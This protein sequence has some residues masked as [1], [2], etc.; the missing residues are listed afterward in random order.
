MKAV[1]KPSFSELVSKKWPSTFI[2]G[3]IY[4]LN[5]EQKVLCVNSPGFSIFIRWHQDII[6]IFVSNSRTE[7][8][9]NL[10]VFGLSRVWHSSGIFECW[11]ISSAANIRNLFLSNRGFHPE[12]RWILEKTEPGNWVSHQEK[13][14]WDRGWE[15]W[16]DERFLPFA[17]TLGKQFPPVFIFRDMN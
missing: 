17:P 8:D 12:T 3:I 1:S 5:G 15:L 4:P 11:R 10:Q 2:R 16:L 9:R 7:N 14:T 13:Q 6:S